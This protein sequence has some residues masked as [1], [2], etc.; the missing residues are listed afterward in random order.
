MN[1]IP[2]VLLLFGLSSTLAQTNVTT[3]AENATQSSTS[4]QTST[5]QTSTTQ[6]TTQSTSTATTTTPPPT[7]PRPSKANRHLLQ[8]K[9][10]LIFFFF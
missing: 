6:T 10:L 7:P 9:F 3:P 2:L 8:S 1:C 4:T 5:S